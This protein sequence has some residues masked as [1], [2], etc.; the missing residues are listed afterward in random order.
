MRKYS[1]WS[2]KWKYHPR[3]DNVQFVILSSDTAVVGLV[4]LHIKLHQIILMWL[5]VS[6]LGHGTRLGWV[7]I[8]TKY[9]N[10]SYFWLSEGRGTSQGDPFQ[11][12]RSVAHLQHLAI[13]YYTIPSLLLASLPA[14]WLGSITLGDT[15][16]WGVGTTGTIH[17][18]TA[19]YWVHLWVSFFIFKAELFGFYLF[20]WNTLFFV[21]YSA[22]F[23]THIY[24]KFHFCLKD[25]F[26]SSITCLL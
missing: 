13:C 3:A 7:L 1:S 18:Y 24:L 10:L 20:I 19:Y 22:I 21:W 2:W 25:L 17:I 6:L 15:V 16:T 26:K 11:L 12:S 8:W 5:L 23:L 4:I 14:S 9:I